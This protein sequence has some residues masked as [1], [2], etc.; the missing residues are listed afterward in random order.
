M[1]SGTANTSSRTAN[2]SDFISKFD[3]DLARP[4]N[5][6]V[7]ITPSLDFVT[8]LKRA[9]QT[10]S[11]LENLWNQFDSSADIKD[12]FL[13]K[14][15]QSEF[16][17]RAFTLVQQKTYGPLEFFPIQNVYNKTT[18]TFICSGNMM[19]KLFF[20]IWMEQICT[21]HPDFNYA[22]ALT[23]PNNPEQF[24]GSVRFDFSYKSF[25]TSDIV[26]RQ[27]GVTGFPS[28]SIALR[29]AFPTEVYS[30][31]LSWAQKDDYHRL[32][33]VFAYRYHYTLELPT[34]NE[35]PQ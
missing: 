8:Y 27:M 14:C 13:F 10:S 7:E 19:E 12:S 24:T 4:C 5:F 34:Q 20:D 15:E 33:V 9:K 6:Q 1:A 18:M 2:I 22:S 26:I 25:Y 21:T 23:D 11:K 28:Y 31:P 35:T 17:P 29:D 30:L 16:P 32:N 3:K